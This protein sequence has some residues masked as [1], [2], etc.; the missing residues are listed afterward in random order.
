[1]CNLFS[2]FLVICVFRKP[3]HSGA[4]KKILCIYLSHRKLFGVFFLVCWWDWTKWHEQIVC[5]T[6]TFFFFLHFYWYI[7]KGTKS[8]KKNWIKVMTLPYFSQMLPWIHHHMSLN[9]PTLSMYVCV[10]DVYSATFVTV[11]QTLSLCLSVC[12]PYPL[13]E[14]GLRWFFSLSIVFASMRF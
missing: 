3:F 8:R 2:Y 11:S 7:Q 12:L 14:C 1:M 9:L 10:C 6:P 5:A 4:N 13:Y